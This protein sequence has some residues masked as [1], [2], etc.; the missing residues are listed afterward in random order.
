MRRTR[1]KPIV[2]Q[3]TQFFKTPQNLTG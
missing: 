1:N 3:V 2:Q